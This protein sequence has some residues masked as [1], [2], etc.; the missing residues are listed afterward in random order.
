MTVCI[1]TNVYSAFKR[2]NRQVQEI[3]ES[4]DEIVIPTIVLGE[5]YTG[6]A[7]GN[8]E[9]ANL[10]ELNQFLHMPDVVVAP[11][12]SAV[13][14][15]YGALVKALKAQGTPIP[16]NDIWIASVAMETGARLMSLD[17]HFQRI[18][19]LVTIPLEST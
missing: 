1:D 14:E 17:S 19:A 18:P 3:L 4:A 6:F 15:R 5:L 12:D 10:K 7:L 9:Q 8:R 11:V 16:T 2:G 13:A